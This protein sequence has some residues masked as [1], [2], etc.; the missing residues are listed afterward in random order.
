MT[1]LWF[2]QIN[3]H[4]IDDWVSSHRNKFVDECWKTNV[5]FSI[6]DEFFC[7]INRIDDDVR[8]SMNIC[9][10]SRT[11]MCKT[12]MKKKR[13]SIVLFYFVL[14]YEDFAIEDQSLMKNRMTMTSTEML[15]RDIEM[16]QFLRLDQRTSKNNI[17]LFAFSQVSSRHVLTDQQTTIISHS[18]H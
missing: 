9:A 12:K 5:T 13:S 8:F 11:L 16:D 17:C 2:W 14:T 18:S 3:S 4:L 15:E 6:N 10:S 7:W 1:W